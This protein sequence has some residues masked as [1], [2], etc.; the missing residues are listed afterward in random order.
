M[1]LPTDL[2][3]HISQ[4]DYGMMCA[5]LPPSQ[6]PRTYDFLY[7]TLVQKHYTFFDELF[8]LVELTQVQIEHLTEAAYIQRH[9]P[10][11]TRLLHT[12][13]AVLDEVYR[14]SRDG[15]DHVVMN[16]CRA[17]T[18]NYRRYPSKRLEYDFESLDVRGVFDEVQVWE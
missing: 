7:Y 15:N 14:R 13:S 3:H 18:S 16:L 12:P 17:L 6:L 4:F 10:T 5:L 8:P 1:N 9:I 11:L 2:L